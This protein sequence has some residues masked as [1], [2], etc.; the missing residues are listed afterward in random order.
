M[1]LL[2]KTKEA[3]AGVRS[4]IV[5]AMECLYQVKEQSAWESVADTFGEYVE[6]ELGISQ[7]FASKL[8]TVN[9]IYVIE[10]GVSQDKLKNIDYECL[11]LAGKTEGTVHEKIEKAR[12]LT[13]QE[14]KLERNDAEATS[15]THVPITICK[16]C[17]LRLQD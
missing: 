2:L 3:F 5:E 15:H 10:G 8:L 16:V 14:L 1:N 7:S 6:Q 12:L 11:Y 17:N 13:R 9:R 4:S